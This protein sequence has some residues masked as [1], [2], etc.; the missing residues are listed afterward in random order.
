MPALGIS[1]ETIRR[2]KRE[3]V[4]ACKDGVRQ[5]A[6]EAFLCDFCPPARLVTYP[7]GCLVC[8]SSVLCVCV[9]LLV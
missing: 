2:A 6:C 4:R 7:S 8:H 5:K 3:G 1:S 9:C